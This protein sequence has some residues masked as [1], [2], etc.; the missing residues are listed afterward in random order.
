MSARRTCKCKDKRG[1]ERQKKKLKITAV[2]K[3]CQV[4]VVKT[5]HL[6]YVL[7]LP[8]V[9]LVLPP[10][11][12]TIETV[13]YEW[14]ERVNN[15][16]VLENVVIIFGQ[17]R[18]CSHQRCNA[19]TGRACAAIEQQQQQVRK[20]IENFHSHVSDLAFAWRSA[21]VPRGKF[22]WNSFFR[23]LLLPVN[24]CSKIDVDCTAHT[25]R[26]PLCIWSWRQT[27]AHHWWLFRVRTVTLLKITP[28]Y[29]TA[30]ASVE[31]QYRDSHENRPS[32]FEASFIFALLYHF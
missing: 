25:R 9:V 14:D 28:Q 11:R 3:C 19:S 5:S 6:I 27:K 31:L 10:I 26:H 30:A 24:A 16:W 17:N 29:L 1:G 13:R 8:I 15:C 2:A 4:E 32:I 22:K 23:S 21:M 12:R 18:R 20:N 7:L